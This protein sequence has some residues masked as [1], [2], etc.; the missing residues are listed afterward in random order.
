MREKIEDKINKHIEQI[1]SKEEITNEDA[2]Y[3]LNVLSKIE[4]DEQRLKFEAES[5]ERTRKMFEQMQEM[6]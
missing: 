5:K 4:N 1:L 2:L 6:M 3:L